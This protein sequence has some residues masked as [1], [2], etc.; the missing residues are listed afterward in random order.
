MNDW[1]RIKE[2]APEPMTQNIVYSPQHGMRIMTFLRR[3]VLGDV[4][5]SDRTATGAA[6]IA[7]M[8]HWMPLPTP[9][10]VAP[11]D[12]PEVGTVALPIR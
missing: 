3:G 2:R 9:P 8:T 10:E 1:I 11:E 12:L 7:T 6:A 4:W 5:D